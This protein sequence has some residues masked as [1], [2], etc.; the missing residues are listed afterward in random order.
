MYSEAKNHQL[1]NTLGTSTFK[2][3]NM[4]IIYI[5][6]FIVKEIIMRIKDIYHGHLEVL[7]SLLTEAIDTKKTYFYN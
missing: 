4:K 6:V 1:Q 5:I 2:F 7:N 3:V